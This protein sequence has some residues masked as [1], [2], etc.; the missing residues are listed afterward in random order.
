MPHEA[1]ESGPCIVRPVRAAV[2]A[3]ALAFP[4]CILAPHEVVAKD[5][6]VAWPAGERWV[7]PFRSLV[8]GPVELAVALRN[9]APERTGVWHCLVYAGTEPTADDLDAWEAGNATRV[10]LP[11]LGC[12]R[13][14]GDALFEEREVVPVE[15]TASR[16]YSLSLFC[17]DARDECRATVTVVLR[18]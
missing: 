4:G 9:D 17:R 1:A 11:P 3:L 16:P 15:A 10:S 13:T 6:A 7:L 12:R 18:V 2:L 14:G 5:L 8:E